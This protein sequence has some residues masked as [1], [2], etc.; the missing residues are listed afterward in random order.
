MTKPVTIEF[1]FNYSNNS[2]L[3]LSRQNLESLDIKTEE[4]VTQ[5]EILL[6]AQAA[7]SVQAAPKTALATAD[8]RYLM[9]TLSTC[10]D[11]PLMAVKGVIVN[12]ENAKQGLEAINGSIML[13]NSRT[14]VP[15]AYLDGNWITAV[16][17][18]AASAL[19]A[20]YLANAESSV[21]AFIGTGVQSRAHLKLFI[22]LYPIKEIRALGRG[23]KSRDLL[24]D[25]AS[26]MGLKAVPCDDA[27]SAVD[28]ADIIVSS[29]PITSRIDPFI[30][31]GWLKQGVFVSSTDLALPWIDESMKAFD[32]II[33]DDLTQEAAMPDPMVEIELVGG[34][35][36]GLVSGTVSGR[37]TPTERTAF[38]FRAVALG[39]LA[40]AS[41]AYQKAV[42]KGV[43][44]EIPS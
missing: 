32:R 34:D 5:L 36:T 41:L 38:V 40:L 6:K 42:S 24:C 4:M 23:T 12:Q 17:T 8:G 13:L 43:G 21:M 15:V 33:I 11:P 16:R 29:I 3:Y 14:G 10:D 22:T 9:A 2:M 27:N 35:I 39:D 25:T 28:D 19:A 20:R 7:G 31:A 30:D 37:Q 18:A 1:E 26:K 44:F